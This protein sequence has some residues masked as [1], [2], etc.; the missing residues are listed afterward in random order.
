[1]IPLHDR[2]TA[3]AEYAIRAENFGTVDRVLFRHGRMAGG[4]LRI[5]VAHGGEVGTL[6]AYECIEGGRSRTSLGVWYAV[7]F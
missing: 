6:A 5:R 1:V 3:Q 7:Q 2:L 4:G